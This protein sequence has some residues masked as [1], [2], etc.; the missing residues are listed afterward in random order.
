MWSPIRLCKGGSKSDMISYLATV[1]AVVVE[2]VFREADQA[3]R[4]PVVL[5]H[6][7]LGSGA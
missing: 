3:Y 2:A 6:G 5:F 4:A 7:D 1:A